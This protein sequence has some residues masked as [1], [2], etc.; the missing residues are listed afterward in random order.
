MDYSLVVFLV[1][2]VYF[3]YRGYKNGIFQVASKLISLPAGYITAYLFT[4]DLDPTVQNI[5]SIAGL[6]SYIITGTILFGFTVALFSL[7]FW[8][9][10]QFVISKNHST[11][12]VSAVSG[13]LLGTAVGVF[14][15]IFAV[16][17]LSTIT[18]LIQAKRGVTPSAP[19]EFEQ[20]IKKVAASAI[21][22]MTKVA[23]NDADLSQV[24][25]VL[26]TSPAE[27]LE[28]IQNISKQRLLPDL[29][30][31]NDARIAMDDRD[32]GALLH[33]SAFQKLVN[34]DDFKALAKDMN[35]P[36]D[37]QAM[38]KEFAIKMTTIWTQIHQVKNDPQFIAITENAEFR[39]MM[40]SKNIYKMIN[41]PQVE[42]LIKIISSAPVPDIEFVERQP[43]QPASPKKPT[44]I[45]RWVDDKGRV[46]YS[47]KKKDSG[48]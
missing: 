8:V 3:A 47:D 18:T 22:G 2:V 41:S 38:Q 12:Q 39:Q 40:Q 32:P 7:L 21:S 30:N 35:F 37:H 17:F 34:D 25:A 4:A 46:H 23:T 5:F 31:S 11:G 20:N 45:Y 10:Q 43:Q 24:T 14:L 13:A 36:S 48:N 33:N 9:L 28:R 19:S 1:I 26:L 29:L 44:E 6:M 27:N 42:S 16:W 15:G